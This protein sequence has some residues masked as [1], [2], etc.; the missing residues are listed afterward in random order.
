LIPARFLP[1]AF[2]PVN[3]HS[4]PGLVAKLIPKLSSPEFLNARSF[5]IRFAKITLP[6]T[7]GYPSD[8]TRGTIV[9]RYQRFSSS[10]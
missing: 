2:V 4:S 10:T 9:F 8:G 5:Y 7:A 6:E 3:T 1:T